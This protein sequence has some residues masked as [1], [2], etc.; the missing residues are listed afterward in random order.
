MTVPLNAAFTGLA[1]FT[2]AGTLTDP[3]GGASVT[4]G[5]LPDG[6]SLATSLT[7]VSTGIYR[8]NVAANV[9]AVAGVPVVLVANTDATMDYEAYEPVMVEVGTNDTI[10]I[11]ATTT[12]TLS[13]FTFTVS[14]NLVGIIATALTETTPGW[15]AAAFKKFF[16]LASPTSTMN[17]ITLVDT[18]TNLTNNTPTIGN[19]TLAA[20]QP[21]YAP[22]KAGDKMD[23]ID[24][25]NATAVTAIQAGLS[26]PAVAQTIDQTKT[27]GTPTAG[28]IAEALS[29][30][31]TLTF[32]GSLVN[33]TAAVSGPVTVSATSG[34]FA[35][36]M[37]DIQTHVDLITPNTPINAVAIV[38]ADGTTLNLVR[39]MDF[40]AANGNPVLLTL[41]NGFR[42]M[43][44]A[45][46]VTLGAKN[47]TGVTFAVTGTALNT[48]DMSFDFTAAIT[49]VLA[50]N[51]SPYSILEVVSSERSVPYIG[52]IV[53]TEATV[54]SL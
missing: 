16:N 50:G 24:A 13:A 25:P 31:E 5:L 39:N 37:N 28:T 48:R 17:E 19:V 26:K 7:H 51:T 47:L 6:T 3:A 41:P 36:Q 30:A 22:S 9:A 18:T 23:L 12:R 45:Q 40:T 8:V 54:S 2:K 42:D 38:G 32:T 14:A 44:P 52:S 21:L 11:W 15:L 20:S 29:K 43:V 27:I 34:A 49:S 10:S 4:V 33:A 53:V 35:T 1:Y 46:A